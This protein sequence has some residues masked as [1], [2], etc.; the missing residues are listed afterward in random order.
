MRVRGPN[1]VGRTLQTD[2]ALL[3]CASATTEEKKRWLKSLTGFEDTFKRT[4]QLPTLPP[5]ML[6]VVG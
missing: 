2:P 1:N 4:Q 5:T 3:H 6:G